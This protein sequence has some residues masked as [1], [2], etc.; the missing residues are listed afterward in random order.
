MPQTVEGA[1]PHALD[2]M[3]LHISRI[4]KVPLLALAEEIALTKRVRQRM[5]ELR[6]IILGSSLMAEEVLAWEGLL[7]IGEMSPKELMQRGSR[8]AQE[9]GGM[10][11]RVGAAAGLISRAEDR[12]SSLKAR[13]RCGGWNARRRET[14]RTRLAAAEQ[15]IRSAI[16]KLDLNDKKVERVGDWIK[17]LAAG[18][19]EKPSHSRGASAA[20]PSVRREELIELDRRIRGLEEGIHEDK[21]KLVETNL[22]L[23]VSVAKKH[24]YVNLELSDLIQEGTLGLMRAA[25]KFDW[26]RGFKFS[27][28][29]TW[30]IRQSIERAGAEMERTIRVPVHIRDR[31][32]KIRRISRDLDA[33][34]C[35]R[36]SLPDF[37]RRSH[38]SMTRISFAMESMQH[39]VSLSTPVG[40]DENLTVGSLL[41]DREAPQMLDLLLKRLRR[42]ELDKLIGS[43]DPREAD[44]VRRRYG[45][46]TDRPAS[47]ADVASEQNVSRER[48]RQIEMAAIAKLRDVQASKTL[49]EYL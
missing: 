40:G 19:G 37:A 11:R 48:V 5:L 16:I 47:L 8:T 46:Q 27:T 20:H 41:V 42:A 28:Y 13:A 22:R 9:L 18:L 25:E 33:A 45:L 31:A 35:A 30:W 10:R 29:A 4:G 34:A 38:I 36:T 43:L 1:E 39:T 49:R 17:A 26:S 24:S 32:A 14:L 3:S 12:R 2:A 23:V 21:T 44:V 15:E 6:R 7:R